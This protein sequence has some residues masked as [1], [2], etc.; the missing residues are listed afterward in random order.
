MLWRQHNPYKYCYTGMEFILWVRLVD[1]FFFYL[2]A[3]VQ[4]FHA[5]G[6]MEKWR[7]KVGLFTIKRYLGLELRIILFGFNVYLLN[8]I[9]DLGILRQKLQ[10][11]EHSM[12]HITTKDSSFWVLVKNYIG[13]T[14]KL[15]PKSISWLRSGTIIPALIL[16]HIFRHF[17]VVDITDYRYY[18]LKFANGR[19][20]AI[21]SD[22]RSEIQALG[23]V[24]EL[25]LHGSVKMVLKKLD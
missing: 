17:N 8:K 13:S 19:S 4:K 18:R 1:F 15:S 22:S 11:A 24:I 10:F 9:K 2:D 3:K 23:S 20:I 16:S 12:Q 25:K 14:W 21:C 5:I 6:I 7:K